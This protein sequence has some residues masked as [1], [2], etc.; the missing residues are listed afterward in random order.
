MWPPTC[1]DRRPLG[2]R[3]QR[4]LN[5]PNQQLHEKDVDS[6]SCSTVV[7]GIVSG[8]CV[9]SIFRPFQGTEPVQPPKKHFDVCLSLISPGVPT[10]NST[11]T[12]K[13]NEKSNVE[14]VVSLVY[15]G[16]VRFSRMTEYVAEESSVIKQSFC[17]FMVQFKLLMVKRCVS[18]S[19]TP[20]H[21]AVT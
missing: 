5:N 11:V 17:V 19:S 16:L 4:S 1:R 7:A 21:L 13:T 9:C 12:Q 6:F 3:Q 20:F 14:K 8:L 15:F 10:T 2:R 18:L